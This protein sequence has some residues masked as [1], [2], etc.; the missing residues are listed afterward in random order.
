MN[1]KPIGNDNA[2]KSFCNDGCDT[3]SPLP[4]A[5]T[6]AHKPPN[7]SKLPARKLDNNNFAIGSFDFFSPAIITASKV[8]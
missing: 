5:T 4:P 8:S 1:H 6:M 3:P 2:N 7:P